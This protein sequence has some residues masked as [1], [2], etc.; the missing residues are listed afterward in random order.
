MFMCTRSFAGTAGMCPSV[1]LEIEP[2]A[3]NRT[4]SGAQVY[5]A[6]VVGV[7][8]ATKRVVEAGS[9]AKSA[10][11]EPYAL[12]HKLYSMSISFWADW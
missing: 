4:Y 1:W 7:S 2:E 5:S 6:I 12:F 3:L 11:A 9:T 10:F 8:A